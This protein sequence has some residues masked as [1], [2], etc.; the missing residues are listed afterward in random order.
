MIGVSNALAICFLLLLL[1]FLVGKRGKLNPR[2]SPSRS[3]APL[4]E[5]E[6]VCPREY[7]PRIFSR[8]DWE[9]VSEME[10]AQLEKLFRRER[11]ALALLWVRQT[12]TEIRRIMREHGEAARRSVDLEFAMEMRL[13]LQ[14]SELLFLCGVLFLSIQIAGPA[15]LRGLA[16]EA[17]RLCQR[18]ADAEEAFRTAIDGR[19][20]RQ[21]RSS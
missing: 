5:D 12:S 15:W 11:K 13:L 16:L 9:F 14:Y 8:E 10:S 1:L 7:V 19:E 17:N 21:M 20:M 3:E 6:A 2:G 4:H 18:I